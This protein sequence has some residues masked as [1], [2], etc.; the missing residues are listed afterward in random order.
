MCS[1]T[2]TSF[3]CSDLDQHEAENGSYRAAFDASSPV[4]NDYHEG[5]NSALHASKVDM[6]IA[7]L[8]ALEQNGPFDEQFDEL[9]YDD[10]EDVID[11]DTLDR[12]ADQLLGA[13]PNDSE[14][15][16]QED[17]MTR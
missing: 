4:A 11:D 13:A 7:E 8:P 16:V 1:Q 15:Q 12:A 9:A 10:V 3:S 17:Q 5:L 6:M 2:W 14:E